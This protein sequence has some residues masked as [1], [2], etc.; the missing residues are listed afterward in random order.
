VR[1][2]LAARLF[3]SLIVV[4]IVTTIS[5]FLI[6]FAPGDPFAYDGPNITPAIRAQWR[7]QYGYDRPLPEQFVRYVTSVAHGQLGYSHSQRRSVAQ[8]LA[9]AIPRTLLLVGVS[10]TLSFGLGMLLGV[11][12]ATR[13]GS[14]IDRAAS[15]VL[16]FFY[17]LPDF[18]FA[19]MM[20]VAFTAWVPLFPSGGIVDPVMHEYMRAWPAFLDRV[21]HLILPSITLTLLISAVIARYQ[22]SAMLDVLPAEFIQVARA[23]GLSERRVVWRHALRT[24]L[25]PVITLLGLLFPALVGGSLFVETVFSWPGMG[26]LTADA[27]FNRDYDLLTA[28]I[29]VGAVMVAVGNLLADLLHAAVDPRL[30][31]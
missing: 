3:K 30:R 29:V 6:R 20:L 11:I 12:Q 31:E 18:W 27:V 17:S 16:L 14:W 15:V 28:S 13:R 23:K 8:V 10:L 24:S 25:T 1:R 22:R 5:F 21:R 26:L 2:Q 19:I 4:L 9:V 7:A